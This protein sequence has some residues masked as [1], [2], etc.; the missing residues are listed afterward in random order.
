MAGRGRP[1]VPFDPRG[2]FAPIEDCGQV[3]Y[4]LQLFNLSIQKKLECFQ[5]AENLQIHSGCSLAL[6]RCSCLLI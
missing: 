6:K 5:H 2:N 4:R 3:T 1:P